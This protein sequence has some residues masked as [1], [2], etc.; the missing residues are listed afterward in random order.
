MILFIFDKMWKFALSSLI[1]SVVV[2]TVV[3]FVTR[4]TP[5]KMTPLMHELAVSASRRVAQDLPRARD[6]NGV[7]L[8]VAGRG[9][10]DE[11]VQFRDMVTDQITATSKY[12]V[13]TWKDVTG[14]LEQSLLGRF[15]T[16]TGLAPGEAPTTIERADKVLRRL[17]AANAVSDVDGVLLVDVVDFTEGPSQDGLGARV[18][19]EA[20]LWGMKASKVLAESGRVVEAVESALDLRY[21]RYSISQTTLLGRFFLWFALSALLPWGGIGLVRLVVRKRR[22]DLNVAMLALFTVLSL[23]LFWVLVLALGTGGGSLVALLLVAGVM[24]YYHYDAC[25]YIG[26]R[27]L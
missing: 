15:L 8:I 4:E 7:L 18:E 20:K 17:E 22:N 23:A 11:E 14:Q 9:Q 5:R 12:R 25:D 3:Y 21:V 10:R 24:G 19:V 26:R 16:E 6:V 27:L 13:R 1:L 2:G